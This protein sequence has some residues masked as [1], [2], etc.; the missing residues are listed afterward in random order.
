MPLLN[1]PIGPA[2]YSYELNAMYR[3]VYGHSVSTRDVCPHIHVLLT[4]APAVLHTPCNFRKVLSP[5]SDVYVD[6][7]TP[8]HVLFTT[9]L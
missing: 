8:V 1:L 2:L 7:S 3:G 9:Q 6:I 4:V 5:D